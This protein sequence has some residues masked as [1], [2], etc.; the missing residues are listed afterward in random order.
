MIG[1]YRDLVVWRESLSFVVEIYHVASR[2]PAQERFGLCDQLRRSAV[3]VPAHISEG[4]ARTYRREFLH[5]LCIAKG[6]LAELQ[7]L[8]VICEQLGYISP[9]ELEALDAG[10]ASIAKPLHGLISKVRQDLGSGKPVPSK[11]ES[12]G[13]DVRGRR[14]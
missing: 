9:V 6:S 7:T 4:Q 2:L 11:P 10:V 8:L 1:N 14:E 5:H 13:E 12:T 3:S